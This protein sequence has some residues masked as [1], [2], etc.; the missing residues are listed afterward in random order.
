MNTKMNKPKILQLRDRSQSIFTLQDGISLC[1]NKERSEETRYFK[2]GIS[3]GYYNPQ[4][5]ITYNYNSERI[6]DFDFERIRGAYL[7]LNGWHIEYPSDDEE[8]DPDPISELN[9]GSENKIEIESELHTN[10]YQIFENVFQIDQELL[11]I[12]RDTVVKASLKETS[13]I[14]NHNTKSKDDN[15][16]RQYNLPL[17]GEY[18]KKFDEKIKMFVKQNIKTSSIPTDPVIIHSLSNCQVQAAHC[19]YTPNDLK[20]I[21]NI[22]IPLSMLLCLMKDTTLRIWPNSSKLFS[23]KNNNI[24]IIEPRE[25]KLKPGD[26]IIFRGDFIHAGSGYEN[27]N[28]RIHYYLDSDKI[29]R[30][31]NNTWIIRKN[32][33]LRNIIQE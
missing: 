18:M 9:Q 13:V 8:D 14:F 33:H 4:F 27:E 29:V 26:I 3:V 16:R 15:K 1:F 17:S 23:V 31:K 19:D 28:L 20:S 5:I 2:I 25:L 21:S 24:D 12:I 22:D 32:E 10:G 7:E 11:N 6:R 30:Q